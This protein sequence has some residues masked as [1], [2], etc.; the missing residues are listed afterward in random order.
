[1]PADLSR[2]VLDAADP[3]SLGLFYAQLLGRSTTDRLDEGVT[4]SL[5]DTVDLALI[6]ATVPKT[7]KNRLHFDLTSR[8]A[9]HQNQL[10]EHAVSLGASRIDI[11]QRDVPW[12]VLADP[13][14][15][16]FCVLEPRDEYAA[17]GVL[18]ALVIDAVDPSAVAAFWSQ[19]T[20]LPATRSDSVVATV[21][22]PEGFWL[23][24]IAVG[25][26]KTA[27]NRL[28]LQLSPSSADESARLENLGATTLGRD[29]D[30]TELADPEGNEFYLAPWPTGTSR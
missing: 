24:F 28:R 20:G 9:D 3:H 6:P 2:L 23:E 22:R 17:N 26:P 15:N 12:V 11:G 14:G 18:A 13:E 19:A 30:T 27:T 29:G 10:V 4:V 1:M 16:E 21:R 25:V 8:S 5:C 7:G